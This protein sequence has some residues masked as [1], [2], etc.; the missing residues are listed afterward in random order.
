L[1]LVKLLEFARRKS[2]HRLHK[3]AA[4][5]YRG[6]QLLAVAANKSWHHAE[7]NVI[8]RAKRTSPSLDGCTIL[9]VRARRGGVGLARPCRSC[10]W[11]LGRE[12][13]SD[14]R[15]TQ[16]DGSIVRVTHRID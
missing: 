5:I 10:M 4:A 16:N 15:W 2:D 12:G 14:I 11:L 7:R 3:M 1:Q 8:R 6:N 13:I 9:I